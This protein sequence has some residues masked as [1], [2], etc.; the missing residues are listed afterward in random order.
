[1]ATADTG[2]T[3]AGFNNWLW[4]GAMHQCWLG[5]YAIAVGLGRM[6][7]VNS[8]FAALS[9]GTGGAVAWL[10]TNPSFYVTT[11]GVAAGNTGA[12]SAGAVGAT[13]HAANGDT[14][15]SNGDSWQFGAYTSNGMFPVYVTGG[16]NSFIKASAISAASGGTNFSAYGTGAGAIRAYG[17]YFIIETYIRRSGAWNRVWIYVRRGAGYPLPP[18]YVRRGAGYTQVRGEDWTKPA[19]LIKQGDRYVSLTEIMRRRE[20]DWKR[21]LEALVWVEGKWEPAI[22]RWDYDRPRYLGSGYPGDPAWK[23]YD[24]SGILTPYRIRSIK[25]AA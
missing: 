1:M 14:P 4:D 2:S 13:G 24:N 7:Q 6:I 22:M 12:G 10:G 11:D 8:T 16:T 21:E 20:L 3:G 19:T 25:E 18:A 23:D 15:T 17:T 5:N 9:G